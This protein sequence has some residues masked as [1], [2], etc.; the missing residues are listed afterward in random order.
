MIALIIIDQQKGIDHPKLGARNN[1]LAEDCMLKILEKWRSLGWP[2]FHIKHKSRENDSVFWP[3]Q[4]GFEFKEPFMPQVGEVLIEKTVPCAFI[5][6]TLEERLKGY[7]AD[8]IVLMGVATNNSIESTARTGGNLG[9]N[10]Y[11]IEDACFTFDK[12]DFYGNWHSANE[13]HAM[14]LANLDGE[15]AQVMSSNQFFTNNF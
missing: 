7:G 6:N 13:V 3:E 4:E 5:N 11:V 12:Q 2:I 9:F 15:Y 10:V 1:P 14:S 8:D